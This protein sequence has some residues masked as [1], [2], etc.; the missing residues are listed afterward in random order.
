MRTFR[1]GRIRPRLDGL[2][3]RCLLTTLAVVEVLNQSS[4]NLTFDFR[5]TPSS[6][7]TQVTEA[8]GA[9]ELFWTNY[10]SNLTPQAYYNTT[11]ASNSG[12]TVNLAQGYGE[13]TG[14]GTPPA[15]SATLY[16]FQN[17]STGVALYYIPPATTDAVVDIA[18]SST[19][20]ISFDFRWS[21]SSSWTLYTEA[22]GQSE[23]LYTTYS[24][25]LA[26]QVY[27]DTTTSSSSATTVNLTQGFGE[28]TGTGAPPASAALDYS[29]QNT[30][31]G[32]LLYYGTGSG[33]GGGGGG[34]GSG[35]GGGSGLAANTSAVINPNW[36]GYA[37]AT[38]LNK[39]TANSVTY[40]AGS[41]K[42]PTVTGS[43]SG[44]TY[45]SAWVG[46]DGYG[47]NTVEQTGT[48]EDVVN[49][50][51]LYRA[52]WEMYSTVTGQPEQ[53]ISSMTISPGDSINASVTYF[54]S[55][56][57]AGQFLLSITDTSKSNDSF[58]IYETSAA[59]QN[60]GAQRSTAEWIVEAPSV[61]GSIAKLASFSQVTFTNASATINGVTGGINSSSWQNQ[62]LNIGSSGKAQDITSVLALSG[63][64]FSVTYGSSSPSAGPAVFGGTT[65][66]P[67]VLTLAG[68]TSLTKPQVT[69][70][71]S[72][73]PSGY[74]LL[75]R[76]AQAIA[77]STLLN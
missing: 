67:T 33:G 50:V 62:A 12:T 60:P 47:N 5:W 29:F 56:S 76:P 19:Y 9:G 32:V 31:T 14:T 6:S 7:W 52:W 34:S 43:G 27:Y 37:A 71:G 57:H 48:E 1:N 30:S 75:F 74:R 66:P 59:T 73:V 23:L 11:T 16:E 65:N 61:G 64:E 45:S 20:T 26:P 70:T 42:V 38:N 46:I 13:W 55:G 3:D 25:S 51:P 77:Q 24:S 54:T 44:T 28:W 36:S 63:S 35:G 72:A 58:S 39:P 21:P 53:V 68:S 2:E 15:S 22:P 49:G 40:V 10:A 4:Y 8:P 41:W 69:L 17:T 18:N